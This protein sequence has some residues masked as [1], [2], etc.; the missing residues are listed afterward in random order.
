MIMNKVIKENL[1]YVIYLFEGLLLIYLGF[2]MFFNSRVMVRFK[3]NWLHLI[4]IFL[5]FIS[6]IY[7][8]RLFDKTQ[9]IIYKILHIGY[10]CLLILVSFHPIFYILVSNTLYPEFYERYSYNFPDNSHERFII[11]AYELA[12]SYSNVLVYEKEILPG[13]VCRNTLS[14]YS[15]YFK[16]DMCDEEN[17]KLKEKI[18]PN[19]DFN[20]YYNLLKNSHNDSFCYSTI[21]KDMF[22]IDTIKP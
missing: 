6:F 13:L 8:V 14:S 2:F 21:N 10:L 11:E 16:E 3:M 22:K 15:E 12:C 7:H 18:L 19:L 9:K 4:M 20:Y 17:M 5:A 1:K